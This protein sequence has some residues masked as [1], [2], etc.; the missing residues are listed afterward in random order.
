MQHLMI[1]IETLGTGINSVVL[2]IGACYF[3]PRTGEIGKTFHQHI[4]MGT[5]TMYGM[6]M[7]TETILWWMNQSEDARKSIIN[8]QK[9]GSNIVNVLIHFRHFVDKRV[10]PWSNGATFDIS[11]LE[12]SFNKC[13]VDVP[14]CFWNIRDVRTIVE[15]GR[16]L[17]F[18]PKVDM[19]FQGTRHD[20]LA[21]A[22]H[23][24]EYVSAIWQKLTQ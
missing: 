14:W 18:D 19:P 6:E 13:K 3:E 23:Q 10:K 5:S 1:D 12:N 11:I 21:D 24:A 17:D 7:D 20:A 9:S 16:E 4:R 15:L 22:I 2:S 8:G